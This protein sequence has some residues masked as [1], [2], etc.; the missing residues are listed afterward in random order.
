MD[1]E[2]SGNTTFVSVY[3][4]EAVK[5]NLLSERPRQAIPRCRFVILIFGRPDLFLHRFVQLCL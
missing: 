5:P 2:L 3:V 1:L 4:A